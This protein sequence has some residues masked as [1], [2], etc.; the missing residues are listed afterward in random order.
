LFSREVVSLTL[1]VYPLPE[2]RLPSGLEINAET[3]VVSAP[4][5]LAKLPALRTS[6]LVILVENVKRSMLF[7]KKR[8]HRH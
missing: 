5:S 8:E 4:V 6:S 2:S 1:G 3:K 7:A